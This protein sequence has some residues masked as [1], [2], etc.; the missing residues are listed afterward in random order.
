MTIRTAR[1][2]AALLATIVL[3]A[4]S[5]PADKSVTDSA[6]AANA[7]PTVVAPTDSA[8]AKPKPDS[9]KPVT[10]AAKPAPKK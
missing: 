5:K 6:A 1:L 10:D 9:A 4:C 7:T 8:T 3:V 2:G